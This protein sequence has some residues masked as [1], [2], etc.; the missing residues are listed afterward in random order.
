VG[1][2]TIHNPDCFA[3]LIREGDLGFSDAY[4]EGWWSTPDL[5][6]LMDFV[7][8]TT[9]SSMTAFP[10]WGWCGSMSGCA[11]AARQFQ[12]AGEEEHFLSLR[13]GQ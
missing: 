9:R 12:A 6:A 2:V 7:H 10:A 3:R 8:R 5:Q 4:L 11:L 1:E 13:S